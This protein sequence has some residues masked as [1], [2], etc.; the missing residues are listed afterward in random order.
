[1]K[2][3][4]RFLLA[5]LA[6][7]ATPAFAVPV[8]QTLGSNLT[9]YNGAS[10]AMTNNTWNNMINARSNMGE[11]PAP[12]ADFGNCNALIMRCAQPKCAS[13]GCTDLSVASSIVSGCVN[14]NDTCKKHGDDLVQY[15]SAQL[16]ASSTAKI[17]QQQLAAQQA[18]SAAAQQQSAAQ[19]QQMQAQ[20]QQMQADMA[21]QNAAQIQQMQAALD[22]QKQLTAEALAQAT[23]PA[24]SAPSPVN[25]NLTVS[26][27]DAAAAGVSADI[28]AREQISGQIMSKVENAET[29]LKSLKATMQDTFDYA[30]CD[31]SGSNCTGPTRVKAFKQRAMGFFEPYNNVLDEIYDALIMAQSLG[32][33]ITDIYMM[34][35]GTCN[36]WALYLCTDGQTM[37][38]NKTS[39]PDGQSNG[40]GGTFGGHKCKIGQVIPLSDGGC[41][42]AQM[43]SS[44]D[45]IL[46]NWLNPQVGDSTEIRVGC[47]SEALDNSALFRNRKKQA[48]IDIETLER[49]IEQDAPA[50]FGT[51]LFGSNTTPKDGAKFCAV[52]DGTYQTLQQAVALKRLPKTVCVGEKKIEDTPT[53]S[54]S[55]TNAAA[56]YQD[57][58]LIE[59]VDIDYA[60]EFRESTAGMMQSAEN[61]LCRVYG[62]TPT[63]PKTIGGTWGCSCVGAEMY[64]DCIEHFYK[65]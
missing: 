40:N 45:D 2:S 27:A 24:P 55:I 22:E 18:A 25:E 13:G 48:T 38:Y 59:S 34:L 42:L 16:V 23:A 65:K 61:S 32:V 30:G 1:M 11:A 46:Y 58:L 29:A 31:S 19:M 10:G 3:L 14:A 43:L 4:H 51:G 28:L 53:H 5:A 17:Q 7:M 33:D 44:D 9:A 57:K 47:A 26:Q 50:S 39:C 63:P 60:E 54:K 41:Q 49:I 6:L 21:A 56:S 52:T 35:N 8:A 64:Q 12:T 37:H 62:G 20:M 36:A 15:I